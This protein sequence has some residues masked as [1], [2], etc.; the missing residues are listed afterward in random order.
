[1]TPNDPATRALTLLNDPATSMWLKNA[2]R[3]QWN[4]DAVDAYN[5]ALAL[6]H[7]LADRLTAVGIPTGIKEIEPDQT[8]AVNPEGFDVPAYLRRQAE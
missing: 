5:D 4:R 3:D 1:M 7:V 8:D 2:L 6:T